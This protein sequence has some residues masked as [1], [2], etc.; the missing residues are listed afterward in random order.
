MSEI[1]L[2]FRQLAFRVI[3]T[4][5]L[6]LFIVSLVLAVVFDSWFGVFAVGLPSLLVPFFLYKTLRDHALARL[7]Y[8]VSFMFFAALHIHQSHG[9][10]E[11]HFG[12]FVSM[13]ILFAFRDQWVILTAAAVIAIHHLLFMYLQQQQIGVYVLPDQY[14]TFARVMLHAVFVVVEAIVLVVLCRQALREAQVGQALFDATDALIATDGSIVLNKRALSL[15]SNVINAFNRVLDSLQQT[16][17]TL[18]QAAADLHYQSD[19]LSDDGQVV[20][21]GMQ[22]KLREVER[23][24]SA[25]EQMSYNITELQKLAEQVGDNS[26]EAAE[27]ARSGQQAV[28]ATINAV[29]HLSGQLTTTADRVHQ[30]ALASADIRKVLDVI[31]AIAEQTNLLALNAAIEAARAGEQGRGFAVVADEV[32]TLASR[33]QASTGEIKEIIDRLVRNSADSVQVVQQ[34]LTQLANTRKNAAES[35][36]LLQSI[37]Q[38]VHLVANSAQTMSSAIGQQNL[39]SEEVASSAQQLKLMAEDQ[40]EK[41]DDVAQS[42]TSLS[43]LSALLTKETKKFIV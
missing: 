38:A 43:N 35:D 7:S 9:M 23:I 37:L 2:R 34:S 8:G 39:A 28:S 16:I 21:K 33:T 13:A 15:N 36:A 31:Q 3:G 17:T 18:N 14:N 30:M 1:N 22:Q 40:V 19:S 32:R 5:N 42:A 20:A 11:L 12:I 25:T 27:A 24:A 4:I 6:G 10:L 41:S 26:A 29:E